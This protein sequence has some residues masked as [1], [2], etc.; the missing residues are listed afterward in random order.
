[1]NLAACLT[2]DELAALL[3]ASGSADEA[4]WTEHLA[5]C[6]ACQ[7]RLESLAAGGE[8]AAVAAD[9][10]RQPMPPPS[11]ALAD[12]VE[13]LRGYDADRTLGNDSAPLAARGAFLEPPTA[14]EYI[15]RLGRYDI[16]A[17]IG[18]GGMG[19]VYA[20]RDPALNR[21]VAIKVLAPEWATDD[22]AHR[23]FVSEARA[24]AAVS[25]P[26]VVAIHAVEETQGLP[27]LVMELVDGETLQDR[28]DRD[29]P[30]PFDE[31]VRIGLGAARGLAAA[32]ARGL[33]HR[34][35]KPSNILLER[36]SQQVKLSDFGLARAQE[37]ARLTRTGVLA[38]TPAYMAPEQIESRN[39]DH[40]ADLFSLGSVLYAMCT[41]REPFQAATPLAV[42]HQ[43]LAAS[44]P[45]IRTLNPQI[46]EWLAQIVEKLQA[47]DP[48]A[49]FGS[50]D[51]LASLLQQ[52]ARLMRDTPAQGTLVTALHE[53]P[54]TR[55]EPPGSGTRDVAPPGGARR[56][57]P[58]SLAAGRSMLWLLAAA[59]LL[60]VV[61]LAFVARPNGE[62]EAPAPGNHEPAV[63]PLPA[64]HV[65]PGGT[66]HAT[67]AD[68]VRDAVDGA[69]ITIRS[70]GPHDVPPLVVR[71]KSLRIIAAPG[72]VPRLRSQPA[73]AERF[74]LDTDMP[75][76]LEGLTLEG[77]YPPRR[78]LYGADSL[79]CTSGPSL[80]LI[81]CRLL[82]HDGYA[83][84]RNER[85]GNLR[86]VRS[87][88]QAGRGTGVAWPL[89]L[90]ESLRPLA[91]DR[92]S[93]CTFENSALTGHGGLRIEPGP[94][95]AF[96]LQLFGCTLFCRE[97]VRM[98][99]PATLLLPMQAPVRFTSEH[100]L[101][102]CE[103]LVMLYPQESAGAQRP[104][105]D[106][107]AWLRHWIRWDGRCNLYA[108]LQA[109]LAV[110]PPRGLTVRE[111]TW[112][113]RELD[114]WR[115]WTLSDEL[116]TVFGTLP[117]VRPGPRDTERY[118]EPAA[119]LEF[120]RL[121][122]EFRFPC[123]TPPGVRLDRLGPGRAYDDWQQQ[124]AGR[125]EWSWQP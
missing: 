40:R 112:T 10:L 3:A 35:V 94:R 73:P 12:A 111:P 17:E 105:A 47:R 109:M 89:V 124:H 82:L 38:G 13:N 15:G 4:R 24:A 11:P 59:P 62:P 50:A 6:T 46:P 79:V 36:Q 107:G 8:F 95:M 101:F 28:L 80:D 81:H 84:V 113:P 1:M 72:V 116:G 71:G 5:S 103:H 85:G 60:A 93:R 33:V 56:T 100:C 104:R 102:D 75:L 63:Q 22:V 64:F 108:P 30:L 41:G 29:G 121:D 66:D 87:E 7:Q 77:T 43:I 96:E 88:L 119:S 54:E 98:L 32:H 31:V 91:G 49:R 27:C 110:A 117:Y 39:C 44:P 86:C 123:E 67:L 118:H 37:D 2:T 16:V 122:G 21:R 125:A 42:L 19:R 97:P 23:R 65:L 53:I 34:D 61:V 48:Q 18:R 51:E 69:T 114:E 115:A 45:P 120:L 90:P 25:S 76:R 14:P 52:H 20:A 55:R 26:F 106:G 9:R 99:V 92:L 78:D 68:A 74:L 57:A 83:C 70:A 58:R